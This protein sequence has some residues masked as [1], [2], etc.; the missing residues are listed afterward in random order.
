MLQTNFK[1]QMHL[2]YEARQFCKITKIYETRQ[3]NFTSF[4]NLDIL[5]ILKLPIKFN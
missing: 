5:V 3:G 4:L 2:F 1:K